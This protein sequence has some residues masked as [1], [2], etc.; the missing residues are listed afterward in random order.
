MI[1]VSAVLAMAAHLEGKVA[2][3]YDMT[4]VSQKNGAVYSHLRVAAPPAVNRQPA[5]GLGDADLVLAFDMIAALGDE[6]SRTWIA[7]RSRL[8]GNDRV[9]PTAV[10]VT[11][12]DDRVD[13]GL[14]KRK[15][16]AKLDA[17]SIRYVDA[18]GLA[19]ALCGDPVGANLMMVGVAVQ[20]GWLPVSVAAIER[21]IELNGTQVPSNLR[22]FRLGR[23]W[24]HDPAQIERAIAKQVAG[25]QPE[26]P[27]DLAALIEH[28]SEL[29]TRYQDA[30]YARRYRALVERTRQVES[31]MA[32]GSL[33]LTEAVATYFAKLMA[34]KDEYEV[35]RLYSAAEFKAELQEQFEGDVQLRFN[36]APPIFSR[37]DP[38][39]GQLLKREYG[40]WM[41]KA[42]HVLA[43]FKGLRGTPFDPFGHTRE[44]R[45]ERELIDEYERTVDKLLAS[46]Q[47]TQIDL[48]VQL[49]SLP[50]HI[51]G[52]GH[53]KDAHLEKVRVQRAELLLQL[54][55]SEVARQE[56][57]SARVDPSHPPLLREGAA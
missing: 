30:R 2:S 32:A 3:V 20:Q 36:L 7:E 41:L 10:F 54:Q 49:A 44:R 9:A 57:P 40:A 1:T 43:R 38:V 27:R 31:R 6:C 34:Y 33:R 5:L 29:L 25:S 15:V 50:E 24:V 46:L 53:V 35:A 55:A 23:L 45:E 26:A 17:R 16:G 42:M 13:T 19:T 48:A 47:A 22:A 4:G 37:K 21:A 51:R 8:L 14:I 28:R 11:Q 12:A 56:A 18:T 52:Y 39:T